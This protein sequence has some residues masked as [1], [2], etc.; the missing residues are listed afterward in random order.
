M[1]SL[2]RKQKINLIFTH[3]YFD[4]DLADRDPEHNLFRGSLICP[5]ASVW[6]SF[7]SMHQVQLK[8]QY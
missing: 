4:L 1:I 5:V 2:I 3:D 7:I 8:E 6:D